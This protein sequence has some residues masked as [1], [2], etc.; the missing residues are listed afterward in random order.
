LR[1]EL[2]K[3]GFKTQFIEEVIEKYCSW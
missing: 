3:K 2:R 1:N